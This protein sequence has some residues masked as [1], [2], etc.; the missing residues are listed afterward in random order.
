MGKEQT[1]GVSRLALNR[2]N[3]SYNFGY[4]K[5]KETIEIKKQQHWVL[6]VQP[7][8][9]NRP[10]FGYETSKPL[11]TKRPGYETSRVR[12]VL[13]PRNL[14]C[15]CTSTCSSIL[16]IFIWSKIAA[17]EK[18]PRQKFSDKYHVTLAIQSQVKNINF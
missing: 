18:E 2:L 4:E 11:G 7:L 10:D 15:T 3:M 9:T 14:T 5:T 12:N 17:D 16:A 1:I 8:D 6:I 13:H